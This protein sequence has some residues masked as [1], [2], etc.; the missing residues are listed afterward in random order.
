MAETLKHYREAWKPSEDICF[1]IDD[2]TAEARSPE[3]IDAMFQAIRAAA[4]EHGFDLNSWGSKSA[5][6]RFLR[7][8]EPS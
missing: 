7:I 1:V 8:K 4:N 3:Q 2:K 5:L 6:R